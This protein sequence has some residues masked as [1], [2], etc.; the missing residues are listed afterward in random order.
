[1]SDDARP[2][3]ARRPEDDEANPWRTLRRRVVYSNGWMTVEED[4]VVRPDGLPG[5]Y[6][7]VRFPGRAVGVVALDDDDRLVLVGQYRYALERYSWEI[8][9]GG[10]DRHDP[11]AGAQ[12]ELLEETGLTAG[13]WERLLE[14]DL[15]NSITDEGA[16]VYLATELTQGEAAPEG[17]ERLA[18][19]WVPF[20]DALAMV[21]DGRITDAISVMAIQAVALRRAGLTGR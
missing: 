11:L 1:M 8:P 2:G 12:R 16:T 18:I 7:V 19:R 14:A 15:S 10:A 17:T 13:R 6:G 3:D 9:E 20:A 21:A 4:D 5:I